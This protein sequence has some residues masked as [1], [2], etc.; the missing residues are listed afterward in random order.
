MSSRCN[1]VPGAIDTEIEIGMTMP[2]SG[3]VATFGPRLRL[4]P[5]R[6]IN[7]KGGVNGRKISLI[8]FGVAFSLPK[9]VEQG[10][11]Q[12][13]CIAKTS[14]AAAA[15]CREFRR[16]AINGARHNVTRAFGAVAWGDRPGQVIDSA[17]EILQFPNTPGSKP[18]R[19][20]VGK[21]PEI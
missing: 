17:T 4:S 13:R 10:L 20:C 12:E 2:F 3:S 21:A 7:E 9:T 19:L 11:P 5:S 6:M 16:P 8:A 1:V 14:A 15:D 18:V